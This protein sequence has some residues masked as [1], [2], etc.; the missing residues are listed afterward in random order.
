MVINCQYTYSPSTNLVLLGSHL[1][2]WPL[3]IQKEKLQL[4]SILCTVKSSTYFLKKIYC[5]MTSLNVHRFSFMRHN[6]LFQPPLFP[7][8]MT[9]DFYYIALSHAHYVGS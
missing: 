9:L 2:F 1:H 4:H 3:E 5:L 8:F 7:L 6:D